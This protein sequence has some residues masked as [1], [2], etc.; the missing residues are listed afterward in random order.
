MRFRPSD[1]LSTVSTEE[2]RSVSRQTRTGVAQWCV[3]TRSSSRSSSKHHTT[4]V[5]HNW[6][7]GAGY[8]SGE[9]H[10]ITID[11]RRQA[12]RH[13]TCMKRPSQ[14]LDAARITRSRHT[15]SEAILLNNDQ[16]TERSH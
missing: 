12:V 2:T 13:G 16:E 6:A 5:M 3:G 14:K 10:D 11:D 7:R 1:K 4:C 9:G 15:Y 8:A